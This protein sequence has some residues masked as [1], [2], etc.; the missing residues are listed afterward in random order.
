MNSACMHFLAKTP[1]LMK[2]HP[3]DLT[4]F[5]RPTVEAEWGWKVPFCMVGEPEE[6][7][8]LERLL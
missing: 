1:T 2:V 4:L 3:E 5:V 8:S 7:G 6:A